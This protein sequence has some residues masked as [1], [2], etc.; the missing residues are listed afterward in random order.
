MNTLQDVIDSIVP[1]PAVL[2]ASQQR[3]ARPMPRQLRSAAVRAAD[4]N[5]DVAAQAR[6]QIAREE[7]LADVM[8][9][10]SARGAAQ[11]PPM[12]A[13]P[14]PS[15]RGLYVASQVLQQPME[16]TGLPSAY[17][18]IQQMGR[19]LA[20]PP[21]N[22]VNM[23][24][25]YADALNGALGVGGMLAGGA[26]AMRASRELPPRR[27]PAAPEAAPRTVWHVSPHEINGQFRTDL[28]GAGESRGSGV[29]ALAYGPGGYFTESPEVR[30][31]YYRQFMRTH[32]RANIY[33]A[34]IPGGDNYVNFDQR[35]GDQQPH[36][37]SALQ[38]I[39]GGG[40]IPHSA[41]AKVV[42]P[43][44]A[45][46][47]R[48]RGIFG[49]TYRGG[50]VGDPSLRNFTVFDGNDI[51]IL[52]RVDPQEL[53]LNDVSATDAA[54]LLRGAGS[55]G[56][57]ADRLPNAPAPLAE[58][59][60]SVPRLPANTSLNA[61]QASSG[62]YRGFQGRRTGAEV[63]G[64]QN[65]VQW[66]HSNE[67]A[68]G[69]YGDKVTAYNADLGHSLQVDANGANFNAVLRSALPKDVLRHLPR[70]IG[71]RSHLIDFA[72]TDQIARAAREAGYDS[73][74]F[75]NINDGWAGSH[76]LPTGTSTAIFDR[77]RL[78][79]ASP[80]T[81]QSPFPVRATRM[82]GRASDGSVLPVREPQPFR[83]SLVGGSGD[84]A[85]AAAMRG[86]TAQ[87]LDPGALTALRRELRDHDF[88]LPQQLPSLPTRRIA[89]S[90]L[91]QVGPRGAGIDRGL[92]NNYSRLSTEA[93]PILVRRG[94]GNGWHVIDGNHRIEVV[95]QRGGQ[96]I[97]ALDATALFQEQP[98]LPPDLP[99]RRGP[100]ASLNAG[101]ASI[102]QYAPF[103]DYR[104]ARDVAGGDTR[105]F[106]QRI[107]GM[108]D[109]GQYTET[110]LPIRD[111][112]AT[113]P[114]TRPDMELA[115]EPN[116]NMATPIVVHMNGQNYLYDGH[117]RLAVA[118]NRGSTSARVRL[119]NL[120]ASSAP[121]TRPPTDRLPPRRGPK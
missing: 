41:D 105:K 18:A 119:V 30:D 75:H 22:A 69:T 98:S 116:Q 1:Q 10:I 120:D 42:L 19:I 20:E 80:S 5:P 93:P 79:E 73:V 68:A 32:G 40:N 87:S 17:R 109:R 12:A 13:V 70:P 23:D 64:G 96:D 62:Q 74:Q 43:E 112:V 55:A 45:S 110:E 26:E 77:S 27:M 60:T 9:Q 15:Q 8:D 99:P 65:R 54:S 38:D 115:A 28:A 117:Y 107:S 67:A 111:I 29:G 59:A 78:T 101:Q 24:Y 114:R 34:Q 25:P 6:Q 14:A 56:F 37:R 121:S 39:Y 16:M 90:D 95:R 92:V 89:L 103:G 47:M 63:L 35:F 84:L 50:I 97:A 81:V 53:G 106:S 7:T 61:G 100:N 86:G 104:S 58:S 31:F 108:L 66:L 91:Q 48:E 71:P 85:D 57:T 46:R 88:S 3:P 102:G 11:A 33:E 83:Q 44:E 52:R 113:Q 21:A 94:R 2:R 4:A 51:N 36:I 118:A 82:P 76:G 49:T 72:N